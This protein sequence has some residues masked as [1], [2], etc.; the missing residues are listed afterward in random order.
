MKPTVSNQGAAISAT[1]TPNL[2][3]IA[4]EDPGAGS[5]STFR[6]N[7]SIGG[8]ESGWFEDGTPTVTQS[9]GMRPQSERSVS[10]L[11]W[12]RERER[13]FLESLRSAEQH[14]GGSGERKTGRNGDDDVSRLFILPDRSVVPIL[15]AGS[16]DL[17]SLS[18]TLNCIAP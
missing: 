10:E 9:Y 6:R 5:M 2:V 7:G 18:A 15:I 4:L 3:P 8:D 14:T 13:D 12:E 16:M 11:S 17:R 1:S